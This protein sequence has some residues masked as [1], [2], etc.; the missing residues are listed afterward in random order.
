MSGWFAVKR[1]ITEHAIFRRRPDRLYAWIWMLE[2]AAWKDTE[3]DVNGKM[4]PVPRGSLCVS[5]AM[6]ESATGMSRKEVR[7]LLDLLKAEGVIAVDVAGFGAKGRSLITLCNYGK[8]QD[9]DAETGQ[10]GAK[11]RA[12]Q[13]AKLNPCE[14]TAIPKPGPSEG[15]S[16]GPIK[17][18]ENNNSDYVGRAG[19]SPKPD[20][21]KQCFDAGVRLLTAQGES[22]RSARAFIG[23]CIR[24]HGEAKVLTALA[25]A[26]GR[27]DAKSFIIRQLKPK[28]DE[29]L[30]E[31][32]HLAS[33]GIP[34]VEVPDDEP[35]GE[36]DFSGSGHSG[37]QP[38]RDAAHDLSRVLTFPA[39]KV[40]PLPQRDVPA[41]RHPVDVLALRMER[42]A[43]L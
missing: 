36:R 5:Q 40:R 38:A 37:P 6:I 21:K 31:V 9:F 32:A 16:E 29:P 33:Q 2:K 35:D 14:E 13:K 30:D 12:K 19:A 20:L 17:E 28:R 11:R 43:V 27:A 39:E 22:E 26:E 34:M 18:Q 7:S 41:G 1:G 3:Q 15:P 10:T 25:A 8:Y 24:D 4:V 23:K 42:G